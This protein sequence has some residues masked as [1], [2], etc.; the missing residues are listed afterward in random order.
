MRFRYTLRGGLPIP[1]NRFNVVAGHSLVTV[2]VSNSEIKLRVCPILLGRS[3]RPLHSLTVVP[4]EW[5]FAAGQEIAEELARQRVEA[6][7]IVQRAAAQKQILAA[8]KA[9]RQREALARHHAAIAA[10]LPTM[11]AA[12]EAGAAAQCVAIQ[13]RQ[14]AV[15]ELGESLVQATI[16]PVAFRG[17][18]SRI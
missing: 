4:A 14:A 9:E 11:I 1:L 12:V 6:E 5:I 18:C 15:A 13:L 17:C 16:P 3:S 2:F 8:A 10:Y 7:R